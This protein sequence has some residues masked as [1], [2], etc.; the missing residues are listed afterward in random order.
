VDLD[1]EPQALAAAHPELLPELLELLRDAES[2]V[3]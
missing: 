1:P 2:G 3:F